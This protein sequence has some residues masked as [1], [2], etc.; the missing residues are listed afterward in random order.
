MTTPVPQP[1][2]RKRLKIE[3]V[4]GGQLEQFLIVNTR[5]ADAAK[6]AGEEA[7]T[8]K[9]A[10]KTWLLS[11]FPPLPD[12]TPNPGMPDAFDIAADPHGRYPAYTM[13]LKEGSHLDQEAMK[14]DGVYDDIYSAYSVPNKSSW[15]LRPSAQGRGRR[16]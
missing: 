6:E 4:E 16:R 2:V 5:A 8:Y 1:K 7:D 14:R 3:P 10:V 13:T 12:G 11:L 15:E 9:L